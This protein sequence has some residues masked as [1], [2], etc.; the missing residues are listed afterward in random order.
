[1]HTRTYRLHLSSSQRR[2]PLELVSSSSD[3][4]QSTSAQGAGGSPDPPCSYGKQW[5]RAETRKRCFPEQT[6]IGAEL[7]FPRRVSLPRMQ[8]LE[9]S[10]VLVL[11]WALGGF[12]PSCQRVGCWGQCTQGL[13]RLHPSSSQTRARLELVSSSSDHQQSTSAQGAGGSPDP[14]SS[15][16]KQRPRGETRKCCFPEQTRIGAELGFPRRVS[17]SRMQLPESSSVPILRWALV[18]SLPSCERVGCWGQCT[19]GLF[20]LHPPSP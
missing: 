15:C 12:L 8:L 9:T 14:P 1:V 10:F 20:R 2:A 18:G 17:L 6:R 5:A 3:H 19:Q 4:Q 11:R 16:G 13:L 7:G